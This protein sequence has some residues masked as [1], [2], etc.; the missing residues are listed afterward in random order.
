MP[1]RFE[2]NLQY[3]KFCMYGFLKN[4]RFFEPFLILFFIEQGLSFLQIGSLYAIREIATN[5]L[6]I[7]TGII[8][9]ALGRRRTMIWSFISYLISFVIFYLAPGFFSFSIAMVFF[10]FGEAFRTGTHKAMI[11][12]YLNIM[13]W[14]DQKVYY[15]GHTRSWSQIGSAVSALIAAG[16]VFYS[17][18]YKFIFLYSTVPYILDLLLMLSYPRELDGART[19]VKGKEIIRSFVFVTKEFISSLGNRDMLKGIA[20]VSAHSGFFGAMKD[21]LQP[22]VQAFALSLP[23]FVYLED[24]QRS[25]LVIGLVYFVIYLLTSFAARR[26]GHIADR[27]TSLGVPLN[28]SL[29]AGFTMGLLSGVFFGLDLTPVSIILFIAIYV[30]QNMRRPMGVSYVSETMRSDILASALSTESQFTTL[31]TAGIALA[32]GFLADC[33][34]IGGA[35]VIISVVMIAT[36]P[37]YLVRRQVQGTRYKV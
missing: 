23:V 2:K 7:P 16:I 11:F 35:L 31:I 14:K 3:Y 4:L 36:T 26:S 30:I 13:G 18:S 33:F 34:G 6:E 9:D 20:N 22:V 37:L 28:I 8:A 27:F 19:D 21:Y 17:G 5:L 32:L 15:Y 25:A 10:S 12:E 29:L 24:L 1:S